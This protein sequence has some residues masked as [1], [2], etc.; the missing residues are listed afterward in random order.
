MR[1]IMNT[2]FQKYSEYAVGDEIEFSD[3]SIGDKFATERWFWE[4]IDANCAKALDAA[5]GHE[6]TMSGSEHHFLS[7]SLVNS[8]KAA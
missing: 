2:I 8:V 3:L 5:L 6:D 7:W 1:S 4:K